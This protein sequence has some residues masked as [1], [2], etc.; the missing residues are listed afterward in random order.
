MTTSAATETM[1][2]VKR[3]GPVVLS[4]AHDVTTNAAAGLRR[5]VGMMTV[6]YNM[7]HVQTFSIAL[8]YALDLAR[9]CG[10]SLVTMDR[11]RK[12]ALAE[13]PQSL[14]AIET[15]LAIVRLTLACEGRII[16]TT[17]FSSR[18]EAEATATAVNEAFDQA[19]TVASD[20]L[21]AAIYMALLSLHGAITQY[22]A[23]QARKLPQ[24][25]EY[26]WQM[27]MPALLMAQRAYCD[28]SRFSELI[29]E[30]NV[31][32]PAFMPRT[33]RMLAV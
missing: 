21:D 22:L 2:I 13:A 1:E 28:P 26:S 31:V 20:D 19:E 6:D 10:A 17:V 23:Q 24:I 30:N 11:V 18:D 4:T 25:V 32:H 3:I 7:T 5:I 29:D 9:Q 33:G 16:S 12:A 8:S 14:M 27:T 15:V